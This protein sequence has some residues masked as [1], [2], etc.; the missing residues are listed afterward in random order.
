MAQQPPEPGSTAGE[1]IRLASIVAIDVVGFSTLSEK[2]QRKAARSVEILRARV[3]DVARRHQGR[4]FN[5]AG[6]GFML[7]FASA[8][9]ALSAINDLIDNRSKREPNIRVGAHVGDVIVTA[10]SDLL[11]HGVNV[12]ARLQSLAQPNTA[13]VS[14]EFRSMARNSPT[15]AFQA[16]GRQPLDNLD[17]RV[18]T[19]AIISQKQRFRRLLARGAITAATAA[20]LATVA[21]FFGP[22][23]M[24]AVDEQDWFVRTQTGDAGAVPPQTPAP[25]MAASPAPSTETVAPPSEE[26]PV[27]SATP[28]RP[29][30]SVFRDCEG[31]PDM[32]VLAGGEFTIGSPAS[33]RGRFSNEGPQQT[34]TVAPFA[35]GVYEVTFAEWD[36]CLG[37]GA[38]AGY[39]PPDESW[40]RGRRPVQAVS[41]NDAQAFVQWLN[42]Q[43]G[44]DVYRLPTEA[45]WEYAARAG[46]VTRFA[47]GDRITAAAA[48]FAGTRTD[49]VGSYTANAFGL[50]DMH[51]N[52]WELTQ[53]CFVDTYDQPLPATCSYRVQRGGGYRDQA[54]ALR[55]A[56][57]R[58]IE[59]DARLTGVGFRVARTLE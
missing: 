32:V 19:F 29:P 47:F 55:S 45:E 14:G 3:L 30:G 50:F 33:E 58:R 35:L 7:E 13:L 34:R 46:S 54:D 43:V 26:A 36:R 23:L 5:T 53:D 57:R 48:R 56:N 44:A 49:P 9:A 16:K 51:G 17:Q 8:G 37:A 18:A 52:V 39:A 10:T 40:G 41:W 38:C 6:D 31:C 20:T 15:A 27:I 25:V 11:G 4:L 42:R 12:A 59:G 24:R 21:V 22:S 2:D 28:T 1:V